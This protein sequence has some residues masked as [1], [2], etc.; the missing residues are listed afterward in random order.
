MRYLLVF[1]LFLFLFSL[2]FYNLTCFDIWWHLKTGEYIFNNLKIPFKDLY[3]YTA[4]YREWID[5]HWLFQLIVFIVYNKTG[6]QGLIII[7][8][9]LLL[10]TYFFLFKIIYDKRRYL[11]SIVVIFLSALCMWERT[12]LRPEIFTFFYISLYL[13]ILYRYKY[14]SHKKVI[15]LLPI[16]QLLWVNTHGLFILGI[17]IVWSYILGEFISSKLRKKIIFNDEN[18]IEA[19]DYRRLFFVGIGIVFT[20]FLNPYNFKGFIFPFLLFTRINGA[21]KL[22]SYTIGEFRPPF[23]IFPQTPFILFYKILLIVSFLLILRN[24]KNQSLSHLFLYL[25]FLYLSLLARRNI[26]LFALVCIPVINEAVKRIKIDFLPFSFK[27]VLIEVILI[28]TLSLSVFDLITNQNHI[29]PDLERIFGMCKLKFKYPEKAALFLSSLNIKGNL[30]NDLQSGNY[31]IWQISPQKKVFIDGRLEVY[32]ESFY[33]EYVSLLENPHLFPKFAEKYKITYV[34]LTHRD[35]DLDG[36]ILY[37]HSHPHWKLIYF[38]DVSV[39]FAKDIPENRKIIKKYEIDL[40]KVNFPSLKN[41]Y[42]K[43]P[44]K[45]I[46]RIYFYRGNFWG[47][48]SYFKKAER[49]FLMSLIFN[50]LNSLVYNNLGII[51]EKEKKYLKAIVNYKIA[52]RI[53]PKLAIAHFNLARLWKKLGKVKFAIQEYNQAIKIDK[54]FTQAYFNLAGIYLQRKEWD[55]AIVLYQKLLRINPYNVDAHINLGIAYAGKG[56]KKEAQEEFLKALK[57]EPQNSLAIHNLKRLSKL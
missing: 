49:N 42:L 37:L 22:F 4:S 5:L 29:R 44:P 39:I 30:F 24:I 18:V 20:S 16:I 46:S 13:Y 41:F 34:F 45:Y 8:T 40:A 26:A 10:L 53:N 28:F 38:D 56:L 3:S 17:L 12:T 52:L 43:L 25:I 2:F 36:L 11:I 31:L 19:E 48:F 23:S 50:P 33:Q 14:T 35:I 54:S 27:K 32:P 6:I 1:L 51:K 55:K 7:K 15:F 47:K 57:I 9:L 21:I